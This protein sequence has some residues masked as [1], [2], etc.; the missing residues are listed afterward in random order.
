GAANQLGA[1]VDLEFDVNRA[2]AYLSLL[3]NSTEVGNLSIIGTRPEWA[4]I[5]NFE[6]VNGVD[7]SSF[8]NATFT[9]NQTRDD[10]F[11]GYMR[12]NVSGSGTLQFIKKGAATLTIQGANVT[13][14]GGTRVMEGRV[15]SQGASLGGSHHH[16]SRNVGEDGAGRVDFWRGRS[17]ECGDGCGLVAPADGRG[18]QGPQLCAGELGQQQGLALYQHQRDLLAV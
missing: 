12:D 13:H 2:Y 16:G 15:I 10:V 17:G 11:S 3:G 18:H 14:T 8:A 5:Q 7:G 1:N 9:V 6:G 4:V